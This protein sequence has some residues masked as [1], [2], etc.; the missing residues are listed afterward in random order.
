MRDRDEATQANAPTGLVGS[1][2]DREEVVKQQDAHRKAAEE[3]QLAEAFQILLRA[4]QYRQDRPFMERL[5]AWMRAER[6]KLD[7]QLDRIGA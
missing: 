2:A 4:D 3:R 1:Y 7:G 6:T 5:R